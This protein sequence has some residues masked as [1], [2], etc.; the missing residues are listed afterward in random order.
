MKVK[1]IFTD[2]DGTAVDS[3]STHS[4]TSRLAEAVRSAYVAGIKV[5]AVTGRAAAGA[6]DILIEMSMRDP[7]IISGGTR[8]VDPVSG[9]EIWG[10]DIPEDSLKKV[11]QEI[12]GTEYPLVWNDFSAADY[13]E[14]GWPQASFTSVKDIYFFEICFVPEKEGLELA[15]KLS[16]I[17]GI[18]VV[19]SKAWREGCLD[20]HVM[21]KDATKE[22][23]VYELQKM[24][25]VKKEETL[26]VGDG[27]ND[28]H[29]FNAVGYKVAMGNAVQEL[30]DAADVVIGDVKDDGLAEFIEKLVEN[31]GEV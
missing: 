1:V 27:L 25:S 17:N 31:G 2:L 6:R 30:K 8:I 26:G 12:E 13:F 23:S 16:K 20:L 3:P 28:L 9:E 24:L 11:L 19:L 15:Q 7:V 22:H 21:N 14:G 5:C 18:E 10:L 29:L 4:V